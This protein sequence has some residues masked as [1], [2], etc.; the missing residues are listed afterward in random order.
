MTAPR[1]VGPEAAE[2]IGD[3]LVLRDPRAIRALA[4]P[5]RLTV[6]DELFSQGVEKTATELAA[7][8]GITPSAMSYHLRALERFGILTSG[9]PSGDLRQ[10]PWRAVAR[11]LGIESR[12]IA[13]ATAETAM[14]DH[15]LGR[16]SERWSAWMTTPHAA[17]WDSAA[18]LSRAVLRLT[19][20]QATALQADIDALIKTYR[21]RRSTAR[22]PETADVEVV[23][24]VLPMAVTRQERDEVPTHIPEDPGGHSVVRAGRLSC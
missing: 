5:A 4:H 10:R 8:A 24:S 17:E 16:L 1:K 22:R 23:Y 9:E 6:V 11:N 7:L 3:R 12:G 18:Q 2:L 15:M 19:P 13:G 20:T 21:P 14:V